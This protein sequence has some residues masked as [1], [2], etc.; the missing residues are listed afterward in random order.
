MIEGI[1]QDKESRERLNLMREQLALSER[2]TAL[3]E[4]QQTLGEV[5]QLMELGTPGSSIA[6][7]P[8]LHPRL[9]TLFPEVDLADIEGFGG[10][11]PTPQTF[12]SMVDTL[13]LEA[14]KNLSRED[15]QLISDDIVRSAISA[16]LTG[17]AI[18]P[19]ELK[20]RQQTAQAW[21]HALES[22]APTPEDLTRM[23]RDRFGLTTI[24]VFDPVTGAT[25]SF[26][27]Q[28]AAELSTRLLMQQREQ[29]FMFWQTGQ[30]PPTD[31]VGEFMDQLQ[32][33]GLIVPRQIAQKL[34]SAAHGT[35]E[36]V[37]KFI[38]TYAASPDVIS[39]MNIYL[40]AISLAEESVFDLLD[41]LPGGAEFS[42]TLQLLGHVS[43]ALGKEE[44]GKIASGL[45]KAWLSAGWPVAP[46]T[47][48][49]FGGR[50]ATWNTLT[51]IGGQPGRHEQDLLRL[52]QSIGL[53]PAEVGVAQVDERAAALGTVMRE[54]GSGQVDPWRDAAALIARGYTMEDIAILREGAERMGIRR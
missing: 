52:L 36:D 20:V 2:G 50:S 37:R 46:L 32:T 49:I 23:A 9:S 11:V 31:V 17:E 6:D 7:M 18:L 4:R 25:R 30:L 3:A 13:G 28:A 39:A 41:Q 15:L 33:A 27:T 1:M 21:M 45:I 43:D 14:L 42:K 34:V 54:V 35:R 40:H 38:E 47:R 8:W 12:Q 19:D 10:L 51:E 29:G 24:D 44:T 5:T 26:D 53:D 16:Q 48:G 22:Y